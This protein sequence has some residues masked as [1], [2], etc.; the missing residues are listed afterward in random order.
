M[1][2]LWGE[3][4]ELLRRRPALWLPVLIA[5]LLGYLTNLG[6]NGLLRALV[7]HQTAQQSAL[8]GPVVHTQLSPA[9]MQTT[10]I[11]ALLLTWF[12]YLVR[13]LLYSAALIATAALVQAYRERRERPGAAVGP[14]LATKWG[15]ILELALRGLAVYAIAALLFAWLSPWMNA[16]GQKALLH[17]PWFDFGLGLVVLLLLA[18]LLAPPALRVLAGRAPQADLAQ[19]AQ[20]LSFTLVVVAA[21]L[22]LAVGGNSRELLHLSPA[23]RYPLEIIGSLVVALPYVLL[24]TGLALLARHVLQR[25]ADSDVDA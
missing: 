2:E 24:F 14:A 16:H 7:M 11:L 15:G 1:G 22:G 4:V 12:A 8:G 17:S 5:D 6:R 23:A 9:A 3:L 21:V 13:M 20:Q 10:T 18:A 25:H 19:R